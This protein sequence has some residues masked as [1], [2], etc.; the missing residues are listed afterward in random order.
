[1]SGEPEIRRAWERDRAYHKRL[2][3]IVP[4]AV[5][6][7]AFLFLTSAQVSIQE[8]EKHV[9]FKGEMQILSEISIMPDDDPFTAVENQH[10]L[11]LLTSMDLDIFEGPEFDDP[12]LIND[13]SPDETEL[14]EISFEDLLDVTTRPSNRD[15]PYS[16]SYVLLKMV[17]PEY[18][19][20]ELTNGTEGSV[21]VEMFVNESGRV[22][23]A[24]VLSSIGPKSF[25]KSSVDAVKQ[26]VFQPPR[27]GDEPTSMWIKFLI[28]FRIYD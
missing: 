14:P 3:R 8:L 21:T 18:P 26:F 20:Y 25:E 28:K 22:E 24:T 11:K 10:K 4:L 27:K 1:M 19:I 9:G 7:V 17:Q 23:M 2:L 6:L 15:V 16:E 13:E 5:L 12:N